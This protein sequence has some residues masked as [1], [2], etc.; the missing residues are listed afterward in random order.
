MRLASFFICFLLAGTTLFSCKNDVKNDNVEGPETIVDSTVVENVKENQVEQ[1]AIANS[2]LAK[3]MTT[4]ETRTFTRYMISAGLTDVISKGKGPYT[5]IAPSNEAFSKLSK[6]TLD[7]LAGQSNNQTLQT[8][9]K[10]HVIVG[11]FSSASILQAVKNGEHTLP[12]L[13]GTSITFFME[14]SNLL[15]KDA[16]G[17]V[18][19]LGKTDILS[20]NGQ[21]HVIDAVL[22]NF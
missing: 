9:L 15:V 19:K 14:G 6:A 8:V 13:G 2:V 21:V 5:I 4:D 22:G 1:K 17:A 20:A 18:A 12:T 11:D 3:L 7:S 16:S 10:G